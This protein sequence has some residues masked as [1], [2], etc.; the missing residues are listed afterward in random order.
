MKLIEMLEEEEEGTPL[1]EHI[2]MFHAEL[3]EV[4]YDE[5]NTHFLHNY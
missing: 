4:S 3:T 5:Q 1:E 2:D